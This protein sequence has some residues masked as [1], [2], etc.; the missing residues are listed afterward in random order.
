M[1]YDKQII[2]FVMTVW[3]FYVTSLKMVA[4]FLFIL[5]FKK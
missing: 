5:D 1:G 3:W 2:A 4:T